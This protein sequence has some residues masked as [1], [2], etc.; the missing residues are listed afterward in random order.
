M[1]CSSLFTIAW[2]KRRQ[3]GMNVAEDTSLSVDD[4]TKSTFEEFL[5]MFVASLELAGC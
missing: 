1:V 3:E 5:R 2:R 4:G